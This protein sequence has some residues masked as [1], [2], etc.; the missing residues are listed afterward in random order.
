LRIRG[1][2]NNFTIILVPAPVEEKDELVKGFFYDKHNQI[3][4]R[5][6][7]HDMKVIVVDFNT[8]VG[9]EVFK[10]VIGKWSMHDTL[11]ENGI[12]AIDFTTNNNNMIIKSAYF[13]H[14]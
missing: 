2:F 8:K 5:I 6:P 10:P 9:R 4:Q 13:L 1:K 7:A 14:C 12:G 3:H 11:N